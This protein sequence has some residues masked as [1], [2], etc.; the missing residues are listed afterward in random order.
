MGIY[1]DGRCEGARQG[2]RR[3]DDGDLQHAAGLALLARLTGFSVLGGTFHVMAAVL[4][5]AVH[6]RH[7]HGLHGTRLCRRLN[8]R[9]PTEGTRQANQEYQAKAYIAC[10][11]LKCSQ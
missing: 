6:H 2:H 3:L 1:G 5:H 11:G 10:H 8:T 4:A 7:A 9:R